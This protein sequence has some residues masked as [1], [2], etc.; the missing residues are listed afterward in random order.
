MLSVL[1]GHLSVALVPFA[2]C[3][4]FVVWLNTSISESIKTFSM[5][6][7]I[8]LHSQVNE[9]LAIC[10]VTCA[11]RATTQSKRNCQSHLMQT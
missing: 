6:D 10:S 3:V 8:Y 7:S 11:K 1:P 9:R 4:G 5:T 2:V